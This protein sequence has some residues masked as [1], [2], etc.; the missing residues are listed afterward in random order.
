VPKGLFQ[1]NAKQ[2]HLFGSIA[3]SKQ[4]AFDEGQVIEIAGAGQY[5]FL[6][7]NFNFISGLRMSLWIT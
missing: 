5:G 4:V 3:N 7:S 2:L 1:R 6:E